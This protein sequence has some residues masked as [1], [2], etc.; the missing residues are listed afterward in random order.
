VLAGLALSIPGTLAQATNPADDNEAH[1]N[2][3][4]WPQGEPLSFDTAL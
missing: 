4:D 1:V 2:F 3:E